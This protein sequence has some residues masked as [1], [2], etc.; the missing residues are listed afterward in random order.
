M[1]I[2]RK[3]AEKAKIEKSKGREKGRKNDIKERER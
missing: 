3:L 1:A 2:T